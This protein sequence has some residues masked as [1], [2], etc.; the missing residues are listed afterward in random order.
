MN[1]EPINK[2]LCKLYRGESELIHPR[3]HHHHHRRRCCSR[4]HHRLLL[5]RHHRLR[6]RFHF[7][8]SKLFV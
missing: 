1:Y 8:E 2:I 3:L 4:C 5:H 6:R 7:L